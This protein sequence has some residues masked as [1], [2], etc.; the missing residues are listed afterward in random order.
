MQG[1][2]QAYAHVSAA[3]VRATKVQIGFRRHYW[4]KE[5]SEMGRPT[6]PLADKILRDA[7]V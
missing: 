2:A 5:A 1:L 3:K 7:L 6:V 4:T